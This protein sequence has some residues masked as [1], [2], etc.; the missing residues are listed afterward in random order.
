MAM[1]ARSPNADFVSTALEWE[2]IR[3]FIV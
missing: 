1:A 3:R 2:G